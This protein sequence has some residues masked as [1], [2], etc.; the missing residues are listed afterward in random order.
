V[1]VIDSGSGIPEDLL[2]RIFEPFFTTRRGGTGLGLS[3]VKYV[4]E[5]HGGTVAAFN[6]E[7]PPGCTF[8]VKL[9]IEKGFET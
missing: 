3:I 6:N 7:P 4:V 9:P 1:Q 8:E 5:N 2:P